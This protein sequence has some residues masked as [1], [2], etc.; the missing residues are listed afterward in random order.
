MPRSTVAFS[1]PPRRR[2][3]LRSLAPAIAATT[4][5]LLAATA[6]TVAAHDEIESSNPPNRA[7]IDEPISSVEVDFGIEISDNVELFLI[8][9]RG[10]GTFEDIGG[11]T[12]R[13][14]A[15]TARVDF[16]ELDENG[17]Y[18]VRY[19]A[20]VPADGH[21][22][23]GAT[24]FTWGD[25]SGSSDGFPLLPFLAAAIVILAIGGWFTYRRALVPVDDDADDA[26]SPAVDAT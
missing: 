24:S 6:G 9:D 2:W 4:L 1:T 13:T 26:V 5:A 11:E 15:T 20:P 21:V 7:V 14:G 16:P 3:S 10:D 23:Q 22:M 18:F 19:I 8:Y 12:V 17:T 25:P